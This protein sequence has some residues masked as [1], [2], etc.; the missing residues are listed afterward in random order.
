[1]TATRNLLSVEKI[2]VQTEYDSKTLVN[3]LSFE[4]AEG[5]TIGIVGESGSGKTLTALSI[6]NLLPR[7]VLRAS[8]SIRFNGVEMSHASEEALRQVRGNRISMIYQDPMTSLNPMMKIGKQILE[9]LEAHGEK[10]DKSKVI[11]VLRAVAIPDPEKCYNSYPHEFSGGMR[12]RVMI[13]M[14]ILL[15]PDLLIADEPTTALD[16]T[17]QRQILNLVREL[18]K[19]RKMSLLWISHDLSVISEM[20]DKVIV[21]Y[22]GRIV[23]VSSVEKIFESPRHPYT[24][25]LIS[26][27]VMRNHQEPMVAIE[28]NPP[29][30]WT[31]TTQCGF[32]DRC[33][34][35]RAE[36]RKALP[37]LVPSEGGAYACMNPVERNSL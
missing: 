24:A 4:I 30:P 27:L 21:M 25:G 14:A 3:N 34:R 9:V 2:T 37:E 17:V 5:E 19:N 32:A 28:G 1:M 35:V 22:A 8:G 20:A 6:L 36:C 31:V 12:Q 7:G 29:K 11:D 26:S 10:P 33:S 16:V 18:Q 23:E 15:E 13:A